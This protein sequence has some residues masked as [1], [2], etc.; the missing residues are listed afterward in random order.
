MKLTVTKIGGAAWR[1]DGLLSLGVNAGKTV[2]TLEFKP[3][4]IEAL[5]VA[6]ISSTRDPLGP[7]SRRIQPR[8]VSRFQIDEYIGLS[9]LLGPQT[10]IHLVLH[11]QLA[12]ALQN[13]LETFDD[14][15]TW[16]VGK[17]H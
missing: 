6:L 11:R 9:F 12:K 3:E 7:L 4:T 15:S 10:G 13:L 17:P 16:D 1:D 14:S 2:H 8:G 5:L